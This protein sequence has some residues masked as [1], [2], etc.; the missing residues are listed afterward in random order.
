MF[1]T[2]LKRIAKSGFFGFFRNGFVSLSSVL[3]MIIT[4]S[5]IGSVVFF[6]AILNVSLEEIRNKVDVNVYFVT[7]ALEEDVL[8]IKD[9]LEVLPEVA[10]VTYVSREE[11]LA[12]FRVR[13]ENDQFTLQA[14]DELGENPLGAKLNIKAKEPQQ[15]E[16]ISTFLQGE[17]ILSKNGT[18]IV[19]NVNYL[20]NKDAIDKLSQIIASAGRF[21]F[22]FTLILV[23]MSTLITFNTIRLVIFISREEISVMRLVGAS[24]L[25]IRGPFVVSGIM[26]G[27]V[28]GLVTLIIFYPFTLWLGKLTEDFFIGLNLFDYYISNFAQVFLLV[29]GSGIVIGA[30]SSY[31]AVKRYLK[32]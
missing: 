17:N 22:I 31:L 29:V 2:N 24:A 9:S 13:H 26:Y 4:L 19:D 15:Y 23:V 21:G 20:K 25:Y 6:G 11:E 1:R 5:V 7:T 30:V 18:V 28:A 32:I 12:S 8:V 16:G 27:I 14:L 3:V 10:D